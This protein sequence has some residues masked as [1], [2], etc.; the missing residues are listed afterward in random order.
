MSCHRQRG[1]RTSSNKPLKRDAI[2]AGVPVLGQRR[3]S[4][5]RVPPG[6]PRGPLRPL[7]QRAS[8]QRQGR[9]GETAQ[10][11]HS[12]HVWDPG[13]GIGRWLAI[14][15][16]RD[17]ESDITS[18]FALLAA[19]SLRHPAGSRSPLRGRRATPHREVQ[20]PRCDQR[21]PVKPRNGSRRAVCGA[22]LRPRAGPYP[23]MPC[24]TAA[25]IPQSLFTR[26]AQNLSLLRCSFPRGSKISKYQR[27]PTSPPSAG[28]RHAA[29]HLPARDCRRSS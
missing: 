18:P 14:S 7:S 3:Y 23:D 25:Y 24:C 27:T 12:R 10:E 21:A 22:L 4:S 19:G 15:S 20:N 11:M 8:D 2:S 9:N 5:H 17:A 26:C 1:W 6:A 13:R 16:D 28:R 29:R